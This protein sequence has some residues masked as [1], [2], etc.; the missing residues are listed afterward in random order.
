MSADTFTDVFD[1]QK[2]NAP[3]NGQSIS[4]QGAVPEFGSKWAPDSATISQ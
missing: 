3:D 2:L 4:E 1:D